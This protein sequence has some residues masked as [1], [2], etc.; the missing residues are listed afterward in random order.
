M[1]VGIARA[2]LPLAV[3]LALAFGLMLLTALTVVLGLV[4]YAGAAT[5]AS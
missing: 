1:S 2:R 3:A 4:F 5:R